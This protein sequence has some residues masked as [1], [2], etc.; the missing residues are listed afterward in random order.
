VSSRFQIFRKIA[1]PLLLVAA[2]GPTVQGR[3][4]IRKGG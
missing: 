1:L 4:I 3:E 2:I